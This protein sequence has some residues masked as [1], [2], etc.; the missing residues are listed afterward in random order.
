MRRVITSG[1]PT[2]ISYPSRRI[3]S[4]RIASCSSP[5]PETLKASGESVGSSRIETLVSASFSSRSL[6]LREVTC[7]PSRPLNGE[8]LTDSTIEIVGSSIL[9]CGSARGFSR[10]ERV[11]PMLTS[12]RPAMATMSPGP[13][14]AISTR[15][16]PS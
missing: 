12:S 9:M 15:F 10:S 3:I 1:L 11:S 4:I 16:S 7:L 2:D 8:S 6:S 14:S 13:A 5:R